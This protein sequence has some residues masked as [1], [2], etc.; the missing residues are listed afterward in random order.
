MESMP[1]QLGVQTRLHMKGV[2]NVDYENDKA[3]DFVPDLKQQ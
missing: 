1:A 2:P 3:Q